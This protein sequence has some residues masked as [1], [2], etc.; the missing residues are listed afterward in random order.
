VKTVLIIGARKPCCEAVLNLGHQYLLWDERGLLP[1][2]S[3]KALAS[4]EIPFP[5]SNESFSAEILSFLDAQNIDAVL[6]VSEASVVLGARVREHL[7]FKRA[8]PFT[9]ECFHNKLA[10]KQKVLEADIPITDF[11]EIN[12]NTNVKNLVQELGLPVVFKRKDLSG[13]KD[14][15]VLSDVKKFALQKKQGWLAERFITGSEMSVESFVQNGK[16]LFQHTTEYLGHYHHLIAPAAQYPKVT[17]EVI[18]L[19]NKVLSILGVDTG[20]THAEFYLTEQGPVF[21]EVAIRPPGGFIMLLIELEFGF[22]PWE[23]L[24]R[25]ELGEMVNF[26]PKRKSYAGVHLIHPPAGTITK[27]KGVKELSALPGVEAVQVKLKVG[28]KIKKRET[29]GENKGR[30]LVRGQNRDE[31]I[32]IFETIRKTLVIEVEED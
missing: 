1:S 22:K 15:Q 16:I 14:L 7:G 17:E 23:M 6:A 32:Q 11:V 18:A 3:K 8:L 9:V 21:G 2:L 4:L 26:P 12:E 5:K 10:M 28:E 29:A 31:I 25:L 24:V 20:M 13:G 19:N 30:V 27:L